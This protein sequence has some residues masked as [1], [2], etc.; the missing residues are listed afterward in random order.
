MLTK[1]CI[2][3]QWVIKQTLDNMTTVQGRILS[4]SN[5]CKNKHPAPDKPVI[6]PSIVKLAV[7]DAENIVYTNQIKWIDLQKQDL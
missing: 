1:W 3:R 6:V 4:C 7:H 2:L 5:I